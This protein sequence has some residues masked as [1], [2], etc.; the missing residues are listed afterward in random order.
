MPTMIAKT[1]DLDGF[2]HALHSFS[3]ANSGDGIPL[4]VVHEGTAYYD[5][6]ELESE[7]CTDI[8]DDS[9]ARL[10]A[11]YTL[12]GLFAM[13]NGDNGFICADGNE[14]EVPSDDDDEEEK[15]SR[16][17]RRRRT[18]KY[19]QLAGRTECDE[20]RGYGYEIALEG[21]DIIIEPALMCDLSGES[22]IENASEPNLVTEPMAKFVKR[23]KR[24]ASRCCI[25]TPA[26]KGG[27]TRQ[28]RPVQNPAGVT[29]RYMGSDDRRIFVLQRGDLKFWTGEVWDKTLDKAMIFHDHKTAQATCSALQ[30]QRY[31]GKPMRTFTVEMSVTLVADDVEGVSQEELARFIAEAVRIDIENVVFGDGPVDGSF[32]Q[33]RMI[34]VTLEETAS[35]RKRF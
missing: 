1:F 3:L 5:P 13:Y 16:Q 2:L 27:K 10:K 28:R 11:G 34:L 30:Y 22:E 25:K 4:P 6:S 20:C 17:P 9:T 31:K 8:P 7:L 23:F 19:V 35:S 18:K 24:P 33:L 32:V 12:F 15:E 21:D 26:P 29:I 14:V